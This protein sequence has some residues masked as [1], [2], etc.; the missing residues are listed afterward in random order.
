MKFILEFCFINR[1]VALA[2]QSSIF[3]SRRLAQKRPQIGAD[4]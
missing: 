3:L 1:N 4:L 2:K